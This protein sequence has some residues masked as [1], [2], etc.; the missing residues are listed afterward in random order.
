MIKTLKNDNM[1]ETLHLK[2]YKRIKINKM[3]STYLSVN[4]LQENTILTTK[5]KGKMRPRKFKSSL[6]GK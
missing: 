2:I 1:V 5:N 3:K 4:A 6:R